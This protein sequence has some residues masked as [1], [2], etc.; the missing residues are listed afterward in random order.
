MARVLIIGCGARGLELTAA[1][2]AQGHVVR[3]TSRRPE[4][5][6]AID[7]AGA[8]GVLADLDR[9][10]TVFPALDHVSVAVLLLG[11]AAGEPRRSTAGKARRVC[12]R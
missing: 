2:K 3:G 1:L 10:V 6:A 12:G 11:N 5:V 9:I 8:E 4:Q 7:A